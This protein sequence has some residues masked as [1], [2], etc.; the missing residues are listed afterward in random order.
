M[1]HCSQGPGAW[2]FGQGGGTSSEGIPFEKDKNVLAAMVAWVEEGLE[3][4]RLLGTKFT[5]DLSENGVQER[6]W[7]CAWPRKS[8]WV[9]GEW[10]CV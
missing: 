4:A 1:F 10:R 3:P 2:V 7:H 6:R 8:R 5:D 9:E